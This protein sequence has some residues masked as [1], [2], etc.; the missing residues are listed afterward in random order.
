MSK[1]SIAPE[2]MYDPKVVQRVLKKFVSNDN[3]CMEWTAATDGGGYGVFNLTTEPKKFVLV[4]VHRWVYQ[5]IHAKWLPSDIFVCHRC[6]NPRCANPD[7]LFEGTNKDN[8][9]D[10][11][12]KL[13]QQRKLDAS[14]VRE[15]RRRLSDGEKPAALAREFNVAHPSI[16]AIRDNKSWKHLKQGEEDV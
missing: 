16:R 12:G 7:H 15:I 10:M 11:L 9:D 5:L 1:Y 3:G 8:V 14:Q 13:R 4:R 6:D 2:V